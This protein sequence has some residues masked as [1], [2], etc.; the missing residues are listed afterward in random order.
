MPPPSD[1]PYKQTFSTDWQKY[2][3]SVATTE[4]TQPFGSA[5]QMAL[6]A[7]E[8]YF[9]DRVRATIKSKLPGAG[10]SSPD[11]LSAIGNERGILE[12]SGESDAAYLI[13]LQNAW[14]V[15]QASG[16]NQGILRALYD[17]GYPNVGIIQQNGNFYTITV[18]ANNNTILNVTACPRSLFES[19]SPLTNPILWSATLTVAQDKVAVPN[20]KNGFFYVTSNGGVTGTVQPAWPTTVGQVVNDN[21]VNWQCKGQDFWNNFA[22]IFFS[23]FPAS[24]A[25]TPPI[26]GSPEQIRVSNLIRQWKSAQGVCFTI[27]IP[28]GGILWDWP[29]PELGLTW[30]TWR[31]TWDTNTTPVPTYWTP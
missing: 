22:V 18:D 15:W 10:F 12:N 20:P 11:A 13:R 7:T 4:L 9:A 17:A 1:V 16:T 21:G 24:W 5:I 3:K 19:R 29:A 2:H 30:N 31:A 25:G 6:G 26:N 28:P 14:N 8:D 23:P 27:V